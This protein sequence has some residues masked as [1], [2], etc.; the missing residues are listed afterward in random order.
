MRLR[1]RPLV[2]WVVADARRLRFDA[3][4]QLMVVDK[5]ALSAVAV[6]GVAVHAA[7]LAEAWRVL[8]EGGL[9]V[10][11]SLGPPTAPPPFRQAEAQGAAFEVGPPV[12][13]ASSKAGESVLCYFARKVA[14]GGP[15]GR[16]DCGA[17]A[18]ARPTTA[19]LRGPVAFAVPVPVSKGLWPDPR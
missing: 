5:G 13:V 8:L 10:S 9:L 12:T 18:A 3:G 15:A 1:S 2:E 11:F 14:R 4:S 17:S 19:P 6:A 7:C 16:V